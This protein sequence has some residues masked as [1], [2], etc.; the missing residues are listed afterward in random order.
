MF[1]VSIMG[2]PSKEQKI[3]ELFFN[4]PSKHWHFKDIVQ[5]AKISENRANYWLKQLLKEKI[6]VYNKKTGKMPYYTANFEDANYKNKKKLYALE[7][8]Y[9]T[10]FLK[11]L[12]S[13]D[14]NTIIIFGSF[15]RADWHK[16]SDID[17]CIIGN[18]S[19][20]EQGKYEK[21]LKREL[22]IFTFKNQQE[23]KNINPRLISNIING[24]FVKGRV[25]NIIGEQNA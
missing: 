9:E 13:L 5:T 8:F 16:N 23:A 4:E 19:E 17:L 25:Q 15:S 18:D 21:K 7:N 20:L 1:N 12:E 22:Q 10:G 3:I 2:K 24:Y 11:H 6:I 14:A